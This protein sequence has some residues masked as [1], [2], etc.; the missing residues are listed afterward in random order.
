MPIDFTHINYLKAGGPKQQQAYAV[1]TELG[2]F[3][4]LQAYSPLLTGTIPLGIDVPQSDLDIICECNAHETFRAH[5]TQCFG[6]QPNFSIHT[7]MHDDLKCSV[8]QFRAGSFTVE[9]F[10][11]NRPTLLQNAYRHM[12]IE[13]HILKTKG[14]DFKQ[15][16]I[17]LK[18]QGVKTEPAF[19]QLLHLSGDPYQALLAL[20]N[21][22]N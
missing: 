22:F 2:I 17:A 3:E 19:A 18:R 12:L 10:G 7:S 1:L 16:I 9:V 5:V 6:Q 13:Y 15:Q 14:E 8:I 21:T 11:Q 20:E 4:K